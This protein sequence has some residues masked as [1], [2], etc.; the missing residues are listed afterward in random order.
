MLPRFNPL[1]VP[2]PIGRRRF[3]L[4][5]V[6]VATVLLGLLSGSSI[7]AL[8]QANNYASI[9]RLYNRC[10]DRS[11]EPSRLPYGGYSF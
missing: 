4:V 1:R 8:S 10:A 6:L 7:W 5:E 3:T 9:A 11:A 2:V